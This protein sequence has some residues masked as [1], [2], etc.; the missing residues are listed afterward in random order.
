MQRIKEQDG[1][2]FAELI[3]RRLQSTRCEGQEENSES[4]NQ[5]EAV[6]QIGGLLGGEESRQEISR[7]PQ[8]L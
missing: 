2:A 4:G 1:Q 8:S 7:S 5:S 6:G 3:Q